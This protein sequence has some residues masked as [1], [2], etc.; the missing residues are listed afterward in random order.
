MSEEL[1]Y[2]TPPDEIFNEIKSACITQWNLIGRHKSYLDEKLSRVN[3]MQNISDNYAT[4]IAMFHTRHRQ[5]VYS[6]LDDKCLEYLY[7]AIAPVNPIEGHYLFEVIE[8]H[9]V[10]REMRDW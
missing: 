8:Q 9:R 4:M 5:A 10:A 7:K 2:Q 3:R 1:Y 6:K